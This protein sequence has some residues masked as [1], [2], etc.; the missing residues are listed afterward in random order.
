MELKRRLKQQSQFQNKK[1]KSS[2]K[3]DTRKLFCLFRLSP[4]QHTSSSLLLGKSARRVSDKD[5]KNKSLNALRDKR[6]RK[7][8]GVR[9]GESRQ[10]FLF[11]LSRHLTFPLLPF[12]LS[13]S[14]GQENIQYSDDDDD[15]EDGQ[16]YGIEYDSDKEA[17]ATAAAVVLTYTDFLKIQITRTQCANWCHTSFFEETVKGCLV[18]I[19]LGMDPVTKKLDYRVAI[20]D[21]KS[22]E[23]YVTLFQFPHHLSLLILSLSV[24][25]SLSFQEIIDY[26]KAYE[27]EGVPVK[28]ALRVQHGKSKRVVQM[29][30]ISNSRFTE[31]IKRGGD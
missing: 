18:R 25:L 22:W 26:H 7:K 13:L 9:N 24:S 11:Y 27:I 6:Q 31:V 29:N 21:G 19:G 30:P 14:L 23:G 16:L 1:R 2:D 10:C 4:S 8:G 5:K 17:S 20:V 3:P 15:E 12:S 28:L